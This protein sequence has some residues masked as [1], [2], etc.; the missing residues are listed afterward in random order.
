M[1]LLA[2]LGCWPATGSLPPPEK[3]VEAP[4]P[5]RVE[6]WGAWGEAGWDP[7][8]FELTDDGA[9]ETARPIVRDVDGI[10]WMYDR[11]VGREGFFHWF[12]PSEALAPGDYELESIVGVYQAVEGPF[13]VLP[14]GVDPAFDPANV[15]GR[16]YQPDADSFAITAPN[17]FGGIALTYL[18]DTALQIVSVDEAGAH[19]RIAA[20][21]DGEAW[22]D[23]LRATGTLSP[24]GLFTWSLDAL[25]VPTDPL[26]THVQDLRLRLG[27]LGDGSAAGGVE[28]NA[29]VDLAVLAALGDDPCVLLPS[30]GAYCWDCMGDNSYSCMDATFY[31]G[32]LAPTS[33]VLPDDLPS[34]G[35]DLEE[36]SDA[37]TCDF[38]GSLCAFAFVPSVFL[39]GA[40][41]RR[42]G[43]RRRSPDDGGARGL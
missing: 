37:I 19:F 15:L 24:T 22:C 20:T 7:L 31:A 25:E 41:F 23:V 43:G 17:G 4:P 39:V 18:A 29:V 21:T 40:A 38:G 30:F 11:A 12:V 34:C 10:E 2:A 6:A 26:P 5:V 16:V 33:L 28:G 8:S 3:V 42:R 32:T 36:T 1:L 13:T 14:Y 35:V 9:Y 27:F